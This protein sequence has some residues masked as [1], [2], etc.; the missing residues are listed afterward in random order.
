M[1]QY[2]F[3]PKWFEKKKLKTTIM[4]SNK[5]IIILSI[6]TIISLFFIKINMT[7]IKD[8]EKQSLKI[9]DE[10]K[11][12]ET[13]V[14]N[15]NIDSYYLLKEFFSEFDKNV[16]LSSL[17]LKD[18][19]ISLEINTKDKEEYLNYINRLENI[20]KYKIL[21]ISPVEESNGVFKF[22]IQI[23]AKQ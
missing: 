14:V 23:E 10:N 20:S 3:K 2:D 21:N 5:L 18:R 6:L 8:L 13:A 19:K 9:E 7:K 4:G 15:K 1:E 16:Q 22:K 11:K 12:R 17:Y